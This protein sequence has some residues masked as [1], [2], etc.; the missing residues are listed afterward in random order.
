MIP[1]FGELSPDVFYRVHLTVTEAGVPVTV[2]RDVL[3]VTAPVTVQTNPPG[4]S[5]MVDTATLPAPHT[6]TGVAG[7]LRELSVAS[8]QMLGGMSYQFSSWSDG[9]PQSHAIPTPSTATTLTANFVTNPDLF[10]YGD[11]L[12]WANWS[13]RTT[14]DPNVTTMAFSGARSMAVTYQ[15]GYSGLSLQRANTSTSPYTHLSFAIRP[16][17]ATIPRIL[18]SFNS[19]TGAE[20]T[21]VDIRPFASVLGNGW[22]QVS[23]PL[24]AMGAAATT[25]SRLNI[26]EGTGAAQPLFHLDDLRL[27]AGSAPPPPPPPPPPP[28]AFFVYADTLA[29][30]NW[31]WGTVLNPAAT[32]PVLSGTQ[33][34]SVGYSQAWAG[35]ALQAPAAGFDTTPYTHVVFALNPGANPI[36]RLYV[37]LY[38]NGAL[39]QQVP[40]A[41]FT[42]PL[43]GGWS[44]VS[45]P[46][47]ALGAQA[48]TITRLQ[49]Q[50]GGG[51]VPGTFHVDD[52]GFV[53]L[54]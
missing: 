4:L 38:A 13:W 15:G 48:R 3:P 16:G 20:L 27:T 39:I 44:R 43:T 5:V 32:Q 52:L 54:P 37:A 1:N 49:I 19:P 53:N 14:V 23:I 10:I 47:A 7:V 29:W 22:S 42:T 41:T 36:P 46:L 17:T 34:M 40:I 6:F 25:V 11:S 9:Q 31:S 30:G 35:A 18:A 21:K 51:V 45:I 12:A 28:N 26:Q 50:E 2:T 33:S 8:P 24:T